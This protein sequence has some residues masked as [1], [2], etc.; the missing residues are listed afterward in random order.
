V[1]AFAEWRLLDYLAQRGLRVPKPVAA[2]YR[3]AGMT[4]QCDLITQRIMDAQSLSAALAR[5][6][7]PESTW[8]AIGAAIAGLHSH[9]VDHADLNAHNIL[10]DGSQGIS[11]IDFD[12]GRLRAS[13]RWTS[14]NLR[15]LYRSLAKISM[16]LPPD[17]FTPVEWKQLSAGYEAG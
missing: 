1:R 4:Y 3:R 10:L 2:F 6:P 14:R 13:G 5:S 11:V 8:R 7:I 12:R 9:G 17:R 15:R 16:S